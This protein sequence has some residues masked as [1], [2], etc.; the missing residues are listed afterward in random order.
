MQTNLHG[1][2]WRS[3]HPRRRGG[4]EGPDEAQDPKDC[5]VDPCSHDRHQEDITE[6]HR[7]VA[8]GDRRILERIGK[9]E[10]AMAHKDISCEKR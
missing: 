7:V 9:V 6:Q 8:V 1:F 4:C 2:V 10:Q 5:E 3:E